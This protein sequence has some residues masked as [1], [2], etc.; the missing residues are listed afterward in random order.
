VSLF[1]LSSHTL[2]PLHDT[3]IPSAI[4]LIFFSTRREIPHR[5]L[6]KPLWRPPTHRRH[7]L[8]STTHRRA[9]S[10]VKSKRDAVKWCDGYPIRG[11]TRFIA[12]WFCDSLPPFSV[13]TLSG[14]LSQVRFVV[15]SLSLIMLISKFGVYL[16][17]RVCSYGSEFVF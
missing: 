17:F 6:M 11:G 13:S 14:Y 15:G 4:D 2:I 8:S 3:S 16:K 12:L 5:S 1:L 9:S 7:P 10:T